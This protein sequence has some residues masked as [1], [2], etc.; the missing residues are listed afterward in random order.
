[1]QQFMAKMMKLNKLAL[2]TGS[3]ILFEG[4]F[5]IHSPTFIELSRNN[6]S[7]D[8]FFKTLKLLMICKEDFQSQ[9]FQNIDN[10]H[11]LLGVIFNEKWPI[12]DRNNF[13]NILELLLKNYNVSLS[14]M[15][16]ILNDKNKEEIFYFLN[17]ENF[18]LFQKYIKEIFCIDKI[19]SSKQTSDEYNPAG[20]KAKKIAEQL[21]KRHQRLEKKNGEENNKD[22]SIL[23][24]YISILAIGI[25]CDINNLKEI[26][27][28]Q[29]YNLLDR[30]SLY[31]NYDLD[32]KCKLAGSTNETQVEHW[33]KIQ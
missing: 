30:F 15:G 5:L 3:D 6:I 8:S 2:I 25:P 29:L 24:N 14:K 20:D 27:I 26:T 31:Y 10:F 33:M 28:Y 11:L 7:E 21:K 9:E 1:M 17:E 32:I 19:F 13:F 18:D 4:Q 12:E 22:V 16:F 23:S